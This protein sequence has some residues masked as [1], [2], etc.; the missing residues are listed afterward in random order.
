MYQNIH[1]YRV[2]L[3]SFKNM[4]RWLSMYIIGCICIA[5]TFL[6]L[7]PEPNAELFFL[8]EE[9]TFVHALENCAQQGAHV[10][11]LGLLI[12]L[13]RFDRL[14]HPK[15]DYWSSLAIGSFAFGWSTRTGM[16]SFDHHSDTDHVV[17]IQEK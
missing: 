3:T 8:Q 6:T 10:P 15:T 7:Q 11:T 14:P 5:W 4:L 2:K 13:A 16:L 9:K 12:Q 17:C 1:G